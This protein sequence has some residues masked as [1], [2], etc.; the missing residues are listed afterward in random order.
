MTDSAKDRVEIEAAIERLLAGTPLR[1]TGEVTVVQLAEEAGVKRWRLTH[2]HVDLMRRFQ[3]AVAQREGESPLLAPLREKIARLE[4]EKTELRVK[5]AELDIQLA[6]YAQ[7]IHDLHSALMAE[8]SS[9]SNV[10]ALP[11]R[12]R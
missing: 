5:N 2:Q 6:V 4:A 12:P 7:V 8:G 9:S 3:A 10:R 11:W 1:S